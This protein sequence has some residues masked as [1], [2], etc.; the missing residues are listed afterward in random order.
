MIE[1][2]RKVVTTDGEF[3]IIFGL[4]GDRFMVQ[5]VLT[6]DPKKMNS[7]PKDVVDSAI[8]ETEEIL[9]TWDSF[10]SE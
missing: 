10:H 5:H 6:E 8:K 2:T 1:G 7:I 9:S 3:E 4:T